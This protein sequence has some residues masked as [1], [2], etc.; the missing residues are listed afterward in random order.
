MVFNAPD[1]FRAGSNEEFQANLEGPRHRYQD[2]H[3][4]KRL[5]HGRD[6]EGKNEVV[7]RLLHIPYSIYIYD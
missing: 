5:L 4:V 6:I 3:Q 1:D 7:L 2:L